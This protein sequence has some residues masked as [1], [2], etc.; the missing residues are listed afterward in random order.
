[1]NRKHPQQNC[2]G[3]IKV[4]KFD[5]CMLLFYSITESNISYDVTLLPAA[6]PGA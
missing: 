4:V 6:S 3:S 2:N 5:G 1:M